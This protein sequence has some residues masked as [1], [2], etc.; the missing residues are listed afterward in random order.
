VILQEN[1]GFYVA[2]LFPIC[3]QKNAKLFCKIKKT[4]FLGHFR[5]LYA[6]IWATVIFFKKRALS[7]FRYYHDLTS[8][9]KSEKINE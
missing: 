3:E 1:K 4:C 8:C 9:K 6:H 5:A 7:V 2:A